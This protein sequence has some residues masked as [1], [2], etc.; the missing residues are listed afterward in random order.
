MGKYIICA[1]EIFKGTSTS[2]VAQPLMVTEI[3]TELVITRL[4][5]MMM[6][7]DNTITK[8][9][10]IVTTSERKCLSQK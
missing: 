3:A 9:D 8:N 1:K 7:N 6:L 5:C 4:Y 2:D 10:I